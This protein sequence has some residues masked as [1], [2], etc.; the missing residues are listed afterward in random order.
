[1]G[2]Y[3]ISS[4]IPSPVGVDIYFHLQ[5]ELECL[6]AD[7]SIAWLIRR[8]KVLDNVEPKGMIK[9]VLFSRIKKGPQGESIWKKLYDGRW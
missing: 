1:M 8:L 3:V 6:P 5:I 7:D 2:L 9:N 4:M